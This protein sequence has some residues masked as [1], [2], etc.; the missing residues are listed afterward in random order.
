MNQIYCK[1]GSVEL[2]EKEA[3]HIYNNNL[4]VCTYSA[5]YVPRFR[6]GQQ[7]QIAFS[8]ICTTTPK[9]IAKRGR[10]FALSAQRINELMGF[11]YLHI[12]I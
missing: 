9:H 2:S 4:Y 12:N 10:W 3:F 7:Q 1:A 6:P 11:E 5:I 8:K